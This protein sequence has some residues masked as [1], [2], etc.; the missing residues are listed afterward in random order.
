MAHSR[1]LAATPSV[2]PLHIPASSSSSSS[3]PLVRDL[4]TRCVSHSGIC[5]SFLSFFFPRCVVALFFPMKSSFEEGECSLRAVVGV[6]IW[7]LGRRVVCFCE[8][9]KGGRICRWEKGEEKLVG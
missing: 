5:V 2:L 4:Q 7:F 6:R 3:L 1:S 9:L 8:R